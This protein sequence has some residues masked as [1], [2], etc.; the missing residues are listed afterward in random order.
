MLYESYLFSGKEKLFYGGSALCVVGFFSF[1][2]YRSLWAVVPLSPVGVSVYLRAAREAGAKR[3]HR[4]ESEF[5]DCILSVSANLRAGYSVENAFRE[6]G[7]DMVLLYGREGLMSRELL[8][9]SKGFDNNLPLQQLLRELGERSASNHIREFAEVFAIAG[10]SGGNLPE[11]IQ[12]AAQLISEEISLKEEIRTAIS[13]KQLEQ[14]IMSGLPFLITA[15]IE[16]GNR[17][18]FDILYHN[19]AGIFLMSFCLLLYLTAYKMAESI[20]R[21]VV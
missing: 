15:Y 21:I 9:I 14:K 13:G 4:L 19:P 11:V 20:S 1:F 7:K 17:G 8:R 16:A 2:F 12:S 18:F 6:S 10:E 3:R 5:K